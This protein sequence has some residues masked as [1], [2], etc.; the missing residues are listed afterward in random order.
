VSATYQYSTLYMRDN[1]INY[2]PDTY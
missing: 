1:H 2:L